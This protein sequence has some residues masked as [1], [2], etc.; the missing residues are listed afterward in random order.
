VCGIV[1]QNGQSVETD[2]DQD[3]REKV[4]ER[5]AYGFGEPRGED[6]DS[7]VHGEVAQGVPR[8]DSSQLRDLVC[9][10]AGQPAGSRE[11]VGFL[12]SH[13]RRCVHEGPPRQLRVP[14]ATEL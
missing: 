7:R 3:H 14:Q 5:V 11:F 12:L 4:R 6:D 9:R 1:H 13:D 10:N 8:V 2:P